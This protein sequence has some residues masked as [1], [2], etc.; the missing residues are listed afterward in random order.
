[1]HVIDKLTKTTYV[2]DA[3]LILW[4]IYRPIVGMDLGTERS[5]IVERVQCIPDLILYAYLF[6]RICR[7]N[8]SSIQPIRYFVGLRSDMSALEKVQQVDLQSLL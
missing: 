8:C 2:S 5:A 4:T 1:M 3:S 7:S 6:E